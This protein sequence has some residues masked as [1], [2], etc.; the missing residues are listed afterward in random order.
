M[1][2]DT[3]AKYMSAAIKLAKKASGMTSPNPIVGAVIVRNG[4]VIGRGYHKE[5]GLAHGE[6]EAIRDAKKQGKKI[7]GSTLYVTLEPCCHTNKRTPPCLNTVIEEKFSRVV[8]GSLDKNPQVSGKSVKALKRKG[9]GVTVGVLEDECLKINEA[10]FK[11]VSLKIPFITLKLASTLDGK[12]AT[13]AGDSKWIGSDSQRKE[14]HKLRA[15]SDSVLVGINTVKTD[16]PMLNVRLKRKKVKQPVAVV[17]DTNLEIPLSSKLLTEREGTMIFISKQNNKLKKIKKLKELG[18]EVI[19]TGLDSSGYVNLKEV[20]KALGSRGIMS[21]LVEGGSKVAS[22][23]I[24][25]GLADK[26]VFFYSPKIVGGDGKSMI[27]N[28]GVK[29]IKDSFKL[30][31]VS[32][33]TMDDEVIVEGYLN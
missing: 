33:S 25:Q 26:A 12:I 16:D 4:K 8:I 15:L 31:D 11:H 19:R 2:K 3:D 30:S 17:L 5:A 27:A 10:F 32:I 24:K 9:V 20:L 13:F 1:S 7:A 6:I 29:E 22:S 14:A 28:L 23:F 21:V 18:Y